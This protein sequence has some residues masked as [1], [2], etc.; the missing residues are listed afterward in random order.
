MNIVSDRSGD[1]TVLRP[2]GQVTVTSKDDIVRAVDEALER[3]E[4]FFLFDFTETG[5]IDAPGVAALVVVAQS[6]HERG[7][8]VRAA[9]LDDDLRS[10]FELSKLDAL[11]PIAAS[12]AD[13]LADF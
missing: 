12:A 4:R 11:V 7:G 2:V 13:A 8:A 9:C 10:L 1:V 3:G 5:Y 6:V